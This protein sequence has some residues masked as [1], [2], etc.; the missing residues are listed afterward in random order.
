MTLGD[1]GAMALDGDRLLH[2]APVPVEAV[3]T[4]AAGDVFRAGLVAGLLRGE[5]ID[6][7]LAFASTVAARSCTRRGAISS[8]QGA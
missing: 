8:I 6:R 3:D 1:R 2:V 7:A 4:T 5:A